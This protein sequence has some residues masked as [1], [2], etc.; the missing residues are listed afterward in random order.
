MPQKIFAIILTL[1][2]TFSIVGFAPKPQPHHAQINHANLRSKTVKS[3]PTVNNA[4]TNPNT[5]KSHKKRWF[6]IGAII[7]VA[8]T[9]A[10]ILI[11]RDGQVCQACVGTCQNGVCGP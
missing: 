9:I 6:I 2:L 10:I 4:Q 7:A 11:H 3:S 1:S 8:V 5:H